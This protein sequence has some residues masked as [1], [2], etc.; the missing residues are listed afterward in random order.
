LQWV[1]RHPGADVQAAC[2]R[3]YTLDD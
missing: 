1:R 2:D 3:F